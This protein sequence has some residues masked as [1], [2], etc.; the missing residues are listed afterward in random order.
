MFCQA[1]CSGFT[2][3]T[4]TVKNNAAVPFSND[5]AP[6]EPLNEIMRFSVTG[7][8]DITPEGDGVDGWV[9]ATNAVGPGRQS[10]QYPSTHCAT[11]VS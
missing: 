11:L 2:G 9:N 7:T 3:C 1:L 4:I 10:S 5:L 8:S 6:G